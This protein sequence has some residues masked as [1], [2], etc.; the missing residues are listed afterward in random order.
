MELRKH[1]LGLQKGKLRN[2]RNKIKQGLKE[3]H[4]ETTPVALTEDLDIL[5]EDIITLFTKTLEFF[6]SDD[7][8]EKLMEEGLN[9]DDIILQEKQ[10]LM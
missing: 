6:E 7:D 9:L 3:K 1:L 4:A 5:N 10:Q 2:L 8:T